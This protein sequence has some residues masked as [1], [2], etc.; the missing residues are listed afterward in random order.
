MSTPEFSLDGQLIYVWYRGQ[1]VDG[2]R[3]SVV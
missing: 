3:K 1:W 2:L